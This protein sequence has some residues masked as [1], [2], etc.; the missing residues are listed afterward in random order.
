MK[1][2]KKE[3]EILAILVE[4]G[5]SFGL[6]LVESSKILKRGFIYVVLNEMENQ[7]LI[8]SF[9]YDKKTNRRVYQ[10]TELGKQLL[11]EYEPPEN[12]FQFSFDISFA[13]VMIVVLF[14]YAD[15][16]DASYEFGKLLRAVYEGFNHGQD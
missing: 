12:P 10:A 4:R 7:K 1:L 8:L 14:L 3:A 16:T 13:A 6:E 15:L 9:K 5:P 11:V 2:S